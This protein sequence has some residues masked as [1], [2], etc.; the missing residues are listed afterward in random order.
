MADAKQLGVT[1]KDFA[2]F[3]SYEPFMVAMREIAHTCTETEL[4]IHCVS[5]RA[6][7][8]K[9][10]A[11]AEP[12]VAFWK[13][14]GELI[15]YSLI[16]GNEF[17]YKCLTFRK[18]EIVLPNGMSLRYPDIEVEYDKKGRPSY[19]YKAG[20]KRVKLYAGKLANNVTQALARIVMTDGMLRVTDTYDVKGTVH[21]EQIIL[22]PETDVEYATKWV[23]E[24]MIVVPD[25]MPGIPLAADVG[26]AKRYGLVK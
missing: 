18:G 20:R 23:E 6:I 15:P 4:L 9:Y 10:R 7:V 17:E 11:A 1:R 16:D 24:Q 14:L 3:Q 22:V 19:S 13:M 5:A 26:A 21:D 25:W 12:V 2:D 8:N